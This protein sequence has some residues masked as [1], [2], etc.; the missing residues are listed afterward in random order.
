ML[1]VSKKCNNKKETWQPEGNAQILT[2]FL[3]AFQGKVGV[4]G[5]GGGDDHMLALLALETG[6]VTKSSL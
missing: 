2:N 6:G 5:W 4:R 3:Q 1:T